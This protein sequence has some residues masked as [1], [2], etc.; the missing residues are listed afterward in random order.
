M[1]TSNSAEDTQAAALDEI[2][3]AEGRG[4]RP[5]RRRLSDER[6]AAPEPAREH[7]LPAVL[8]GAVVCGSVLAIGTVHLPVLLVVAAGAFAAAAVALHRAAQ[9]RRGAGLPF[10]SLVFAALAAYT[11]LQALPMP[12]GWLKVIAPANADVWERCLFPFGEAG[13]RWAS[14][15][16]DP[17]ASVVEALK[18]STYAAVFTAAAALG[19]RKGAGWGIAMVFGTAVAAALTTLGHGILGA[20]RVYGLYQPNFNV[21]GWHVGPLLNPNNLAGYLNLGIL[22]GLGLLLSHRPL[23]PRWVVGFGVALMVAIDVTSASRG[24]VL[25]LPLGVVA[26]SL[27]TSRRN[28]ERWATDKASTWLLFAVIA[29]GAFL[30]IL[31]GNDKAWAELY[32]KNLS[33]WKMLLWVKPL[34]ADHPLFGIGRGAFESVFPAYRV[35]PGNLVFTHAENF[36]LQWVAEWGLPVGLAA[37]GALAWTLSPRRLGLTRSALAAGAWLGVAV[38]L[39]QNLVDLALEV[40]AVCIGAA[41]VLGSLWGDPVTHGTRRG[42]RREPLAERWPRALPVTIVAMGA[43]LIAGAVRFGWHDVAADR[44]ALWATL[45]SARALRAGQAAPLRDAVRRAMLRHPAEPYFSLVGGTAAFRARDQSPIPWIQRT[46]ERGQVN[47]RAHLLLAEVLAARGSRRQ[48]LLELRLSL[49]NEPALIAPVAALSIRWTQDLDELIA[50]LPDGKAG[51][52]VLAEMARLLAITPRPGEKGGDPL[53]RGRCDRE[54]ILRDPTLIAPRVREAEARLLAMAKDAPPGGLCVDRALCHAEI[55]AHAA[56]ITAAQPDA[57][58]A[59]ELHARLLLAEDKPDEAVKFLEKAC[60]QVTDRP[61]CLQARVGAAARL[62]P[63]EPL[64]AAMKALLGASCSS[65]EAC[66]NAATWLASVR[67]GRGEMGAALALLARAARED[68]GDDSRLLKLADAASR[69]GAHA[70]A[71]DA[72]ETVSRRHGGADPEI[73]Q[74]AEAERSQARARLL[75]H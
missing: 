6:V 13:P 66:A 35:T 33:K 25:T 14:L 21:L 30:A 43:A 55:L 73:K 9:A 36:P 34:V 48:A 41:T 49:E 52:P 27:I 1:T 67:Q 64:D 29:G 11:L 3:P 61:S 4:R 31:G 12:I 70:Q 24:G 39:L 38:L 51:A 2:P 32:D 19:A 40:P 69:A 23:L 37:L 59:V 63:S 5:R 45:D 42:T 8:L 16:L 46:L 10:P 65:A 72:L 56:A 53:L 50:T 15:S 68:P 20:T 58:I 74:R 71:A 7:L 18:W 54:A 62:K 28:K 26:L 17:G 75:E 57:S 44:A 47:G 60:E 22:S